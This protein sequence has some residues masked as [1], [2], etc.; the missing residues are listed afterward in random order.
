MKV[1]SPEPLLCVDMTEKTIVRENLMTEQ[2]YS[3]YCGNNIGRDFK[4]GCHNPRTVFDGDQFV[5][6]N[7]AYR[8]T[9]PPD[10]IHRYKAK[11][12]LK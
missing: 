1:F 3:P 9:F 12:N 11:W 7:C 6:P 2:G 10:F 5:C 8:T 4:N